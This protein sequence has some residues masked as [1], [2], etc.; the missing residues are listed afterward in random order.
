MDLIEAAELHVGLF[1]GDAGIQ[2][3]PEKLQSRLLE[4]KASRIR[5]CPE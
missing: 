4:G 2:R 5:A 3:V 1:S